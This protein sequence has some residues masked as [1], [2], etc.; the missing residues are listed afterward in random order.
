M[1]SMASIFEDRGDPWVTEKEGIKLFGRNVVTENPDRDQYAAAKALFKPVYV[2]PP[3]T[4]Q[5]T[6]EHRRLANISRRANAA[7]NSRVVRK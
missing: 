5:K 3:K 1:S 4:E 2:D 6:T 7:I